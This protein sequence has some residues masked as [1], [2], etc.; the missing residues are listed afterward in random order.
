MR[1]TKKEADTNRRGARRLQTSVS[2][3]AISLAAGLSQQ[4]F[5]QE[6]DSDA[7]SVTVLDTITITARKRPENPQDVPISMTVIPG[8][9]VDTS[10][11]SSNA[12]L[13]RSAPNMTFI[14]GGGLFGNS[15]NLRGVGSV[16]PLSPDDTSVVFYVDEMPL[17]VLGIAPNLMDTE[18]VEVLRGPQGT[19]FGRNTQGGAVNIV[20]RRP[21]FDREFSLTG[22]VGTDG[23][24]LGQLIANGTLVPDN[25]AGRLA[26]RW[27]SFDGDIP[28]IAA[29]GKDGGLDIGAARGSLLFT[30]SDR[31][32]ALL[33]FNYGRE[34]THSPR[35][36]LRD[37]PDFPI[38][39]T[40]PRTRVEGESYGVNLRVQH[41]FDSFMLNTQTAFQRGQSENTFDPTDS[42]VFGQMPPGS[43]VPPPYTVPGADFSTLSLDESSFVQEVR[44]SSL[45]E[46][47]I[48]WTAGFNYFRSDY[49]AGRDAHALTPAFVN[50]NGIQDNDFLVNSYALFGEVTVPLTERLKATVGLRGTHESKS[51][52]FNFDPNG[53]PGVGTGFTQD[54]SLSESFLTGRAALSYDWTPDL[55]TYVS[56]GRGYVSSGFPAYS[57]NSALERPD[58]PFPASTS[59]TYEAGFKSRLLDERLSLS[60]SLFFNDVKSG[61]LVYFDPSRAIFTTVALDYQTYGGEIELSAEVT[62]DFTVFGGLGYTHAELRNI[63]SG[64][65]SGAQSGNDVPNVPAFTVNLGAEYRWSAETIG[66]PGDFTGRVTYQHVDSRAANVQNSFDLDAYDIV[67][68]KLTWTHDDVSVYAF[69]NN[70]FDERYE[71]WGQNFGPVESVRA[72]QGRIVGIGASFQ[73]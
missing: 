21:T 63:P 5:A 19:L 55:M 43:I 22:E 65:V 47:P 67:N 23:Y 8:N 40:D 50:L 17:S 7:P 4:S 26:V 41:E 11:A 42:L 10:P 60:G 45:P 71:A 14:D 72:G 49:S 52:H 29:G 31:T 46:S 33:T 32:E 13:T 1:D 39:A 36:I 28:N 73:F 38:S 51:A 20:S 70:L 68:A 64:H 24:L 54:A 53:L 44:L 61:H 27:N 12:A 58:G 9:E 59:W 66:L 62:P 69:A 56:F 30:P 57:V 37:A 25:L 6:V 48:A 18:R 35:F 3:L 34:V 16:S 2:I 15:V